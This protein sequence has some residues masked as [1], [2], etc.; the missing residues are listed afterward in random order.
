MTGL[1]PT[2]DRNVTSPANEWLR[3]ASDIIE[4]P[5]LMTTTFPAKRWMYGKASIKI[6]AL[7][8]AV[9]IRDFAGSGRECPVVISCAPR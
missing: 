6:E 4:P 9:A 2:V 7:P 1:T 8:M 5:Y 3:S